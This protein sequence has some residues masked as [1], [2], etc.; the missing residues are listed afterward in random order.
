MN[1]VKGD[2]YEDYVLDK[3]NSNDG[4]DLWNWKYVPEYILIDYGF[5]HDMNEHRLL[6]KKIKLENNVKYFNCLIDTGIDL[7]GFDSN[8]KLI[9][10]QCKNGYSN[11]LTISNISTFYFMMFNY[12]KI[13][14]GYVYYTDKIHYLLK[15]HS[16]NDKIEYVKCEI[17][18]ADDDDLKIDNS[19]SDISNTKTSSNKII[20]K[21]Y[22]YQKDAVKKIK[23]FFK[24]DNNI[25]GQ[26]SI[27]CGCGKTLISFLIAC[28]YKNIIIISPLKQFAEQNL[29]R[30]CEYDNNLISNS[31]LIDTDGTRDLIKINKFIKKR[32]DN[33]ILFS[34][35]YKSVD[36][37]NQIL[38]NL[39]MDETIII[40]DEFHNISITNL[41]NPN[42]AI[43]QLLNSKQRILFL[44]A[45]PRIYELENSNYEDFDIS[46]MIGKIIYSMN[47][48]YAIQNKFICDYNIC[49]PSITLKN[50]LLYDDI[51]KEIDIKLI[52]EDYLAKSTYIYKCLGYYGSKKLIV[53]CKDTEDLYKLKNAIKNL[54]TFYCQDDIWLNEIISSTP[55]SKSN[56]FTKDTNSREYILNQFELNTNLS[57]LFSIQILD[58]CIDIPSCD[59]IFISYPT[60]SKIRTIQRMCRAMRTIKSKPNKKAN[61]Y[62]WCS[63]Y[64][65][66][67]DCLSSLKEYDTELTT[68]IKLV[69]SHLVKLNTEEN[70]LV[71]NETKKITDYVVG[72]KEFRFYT[73]NEKLQMLKDFIDVNGYRPR[74][75]TTDKYEL[76]IGQWLSRQ[77]QNYKDKKESM[78]IT[79]NYNTWTEFINDKKYIT[80]MKKLN[81]VNIE[82]WRK[83][84]KLLKEFI[85]KNK[86]R[87]NNKNDNKLEKSLAYWIDAQNEN[88]RENKMPNEDIKNIWTDFKENDENYNYIITKEEIW[89]NNLEELK[90]Y[91]NINK[92]FIIGNNSHNS[93]ISKWFNEQSKQYDDNKMTEQRKILWKEFIE[94][95]KYNQYFRIDNEDLW[96]NNLQ[97]LKK[98]I[99]ENN[100]K[101][102]H[103]NY[104][105]KEKFKND[106]EKKEYEEME[107][108]IKKHNYLVHWVSDQSADYKQNKLSENRTKK[109][110]EF[111]EDDKYSKYFITSEEH[112][113]LQFEKMKKFII[114]YKKRP[115]RSG[116]IDGVINE[117]IKTLGG[118]LHSQLFNYKNK[119]STVYKIEEIRKAWEEISV[120]DLFAE[121]LKTE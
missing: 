105:R 99:D 119:K 64:N 71:K 23:Q 40:F 81:D 79:S 117:E 6:K 60:T 69:D 56:D 13:T 112:W 103:I 114:K 15:E 58:E 1:K 113:F 55:H 53:Y 8:N 77:I 59:S 116:L 18:N 42:D 11:G 70:D 32:K 17:K 102:S 30:Y 27:P 96:N 57:I 22:Q 95:T 106:K 104:T 12:S 47:F 39:D 54:S 46:N 3:L 121:Y 72:I 4:Y 73:W 68:K 62:L 2:K 48:S 109:W 49:L 5:I 82:K 83:N 25:R 91:I 33:T 75:H 108:K 67:L 31:L 89:I 100:K 107:N 52:D 41:T 35:T 115:P 10:I 36:V 88:Y 14:K 38:T 76:G 63:Q 34:S 84:F 43:N 19:S 93:Y 78:N 85:T 7:L 45:T 120:D 26:L 80:H 97:D 101:L 50:D 74:V 118:W 61:I 21:P 51:K 44:S 24:D 66:L 92:K 20:I 110:K 98:F 94:N 86:R 16:I 9:A 65:E 29:M 111:I 37:I 90:L 28:K 87:P